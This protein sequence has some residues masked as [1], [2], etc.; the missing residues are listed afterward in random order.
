MQ[1]SW[2]DL[3]ESSIL[4]YYITEVTFTQS[5]YYFCFIHDLHQCLSFQSN[6]MSQELKS[7]LKTKKAS[8]K[9]WLPFSLIW[10]I[11]STLPLDG[12]RQ[13]IFFFHH[14]VPVQLNPIYIH[15]YTAFSMFTKL[16]SRFRHLIALYE[17][18]L[19]IMTCSYARAY[20]C[21]SVYLSVCVHQSHNRLYQSSCNQ[22]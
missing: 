13:H 22:F 4:P 11:I 8:A 14:F 17:L 18:G 20:V 10:K 2:T 1:Y 19:R 5:Y 6:L 7:V 9:S 15:I 12:H 3:W 16:V 21:L